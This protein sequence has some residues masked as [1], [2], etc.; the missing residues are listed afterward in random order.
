MCCINFLGKNLNIDFF[1]C[2]ML[3]TLTLRQISETVHDENLYHALYITAG[4]VNWPDFGG[5]ERVRNSYFF[6]FSMWVKRLLVLCT[7]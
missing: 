1:F 2:R 5:Y 4:S 3:F 7:C 6:S